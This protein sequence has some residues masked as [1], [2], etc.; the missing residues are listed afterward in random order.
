[1]SRLSKKSLF[2]LEIL[3]ISRWSLT[4]QLLKS[5]AVLIISIFNYELECLISGTSVQNLQT[6][7]FHGHEICKICIFKRP[8][9]ITYSRINIHC[10]IPDLPSTNQN[11]KSQRKWIKNQ[12]NVEDVSLF[13]EAE[14]PNLEKKSQTSWRG[15]NDRITLSHKV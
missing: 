1:M 8:K 12:L 14:E 10:H 6:G 15:H 3:S 7:C 11:W 9:T 13:Q 2:F 5:F 4:H